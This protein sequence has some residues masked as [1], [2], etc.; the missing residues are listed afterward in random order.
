MKSL[1][2][3]N[4]K[5]L[6]GGIQ[7]GQ[8]RDGHPQSALLFLCKVSFSHQE[9]IQRNIKKCCKLYGQLDWASLLSGF[10]FCDVWSADIHL[11]CQ[12]L[13]CEPTLFSDRKSVV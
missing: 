11:L 2:T 8:Q 9:I 12:L 4:G 3:Q 5:F 10:D 6:E 7:F 13:L 1:P